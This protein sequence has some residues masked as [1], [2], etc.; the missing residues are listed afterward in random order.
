MLLLHELGIVKN[1]IQQLQTS[2]N[3]R[4]NLMPLIPGCFENPIWKWIL[5]FLTPLFLIFLLL[6][7][8]PCFINFLSTFLQWQIK[9]KS[10]NQ[11]IGSSYRIA[12][13]CPQKSLMPTTIKKSLWWGSVTPQN[14]W[15]PCGKQFKRSNA[16][17]PASPSPPLFFHFPLYDKKM[18]GRLA[19]R[20]IHR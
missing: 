4:N 11:L 7:F 12:N 19:M 18:R 20:H 6:Q 1:K 14:W 15:H 13:H 9:K 8:S 5:C 10:S 17:I 2:K 3:I 16:P